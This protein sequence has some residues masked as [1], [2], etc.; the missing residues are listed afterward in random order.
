MSTFKGKR[1]F[2]E[3]DDGYALTLIQHLLLLL[4]TFEKFGEFIVYRKLM[5]YF[6]WQQCSARFDVY[7]V[8]RA[9]DRRDDTD[10]EVCLFFYYFYK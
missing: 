2:T 6:E 3:C 4:L 5:K 8:K 7:D 1:V 9:F 10:D